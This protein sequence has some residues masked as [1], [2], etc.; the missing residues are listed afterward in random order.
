MGK[1]TGKEMNYARCLTIDLKE[2]EFPMKTILEIL[3]LSTEYLISRGIDN[4]R[5]EAEELLASALSC[6]RV[7]LYMEFDRPLTEEELATCRSHI[8]RRARGEPRQYIM[9]E[10]DFM[11]CTIKVSPDVLIPR[12]ETEILAHII[13]K[14][15]SKMDLQGKVLWDLCCGSGCLGI[16]LK[17]AFPQLNVFLSDISPAALAVA[18]ANALLNE[19]DVACLE[20]DLCTPFTNQAHFVVSNPPYIAESEFHDLEREVREFEPKIALVGGKRGIEFYERLAATLPPRL[21]SKGEVWLEIGATQHT[22]LTNVFTNPPWKKSF[23]E[24]D[25]AG[26]DRFFFLEIE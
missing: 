21:I 22:L 11:G 12:Q 26:H 7:C 24:K 17:K 6:T 3:K 1:G 2:V 10:V 8:V 15:L 14:K 13:A 5:R 16:S 25:W 20:G 23:I 9:G 19:V 4:A 18:R